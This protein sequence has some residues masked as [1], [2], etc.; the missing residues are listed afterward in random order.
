MRKFD[1]G[2]IGCGPAGFAA[3]MRCVDFGK[4]VCLVECAD[5]GGTGIVNGALASKTMWELSGDYA[6]ASRVDRGYRAGPDV[7]L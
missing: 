1:V 4:S 7:R 6:V 3:T 2:I 5:I